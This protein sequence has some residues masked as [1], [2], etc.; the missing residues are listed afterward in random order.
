MGGHSDLRG[1]RLIWG[2]Q[3]APC[4]SGEHTE[5]AQCQPTR[6]G[7][8]SHAPT[9]ALQGWTQEEEDN[10]GRREERESWEAAGQGHGKKGMVHEPRAAAVSGQME[11]SVEAG[12]LG[13]V[14]GAFQWSAGGR[15][16]VAVS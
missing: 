16:H 4:M 9:P 12:S 10:G 7:E 6:G 11:T 8:W 5:T 3:H 2:H 1:E 13:I 15:R 14:A